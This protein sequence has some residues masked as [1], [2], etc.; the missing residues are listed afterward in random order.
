MVGDHTGSAGAVGSLFSR[1]GILIFLF[2][3]R[4]HH[5]RIASSLFASTNTTT[6]LPPYWV[7]EVFTPIHTCIH[8]Y[9]SSSLS[10]QISIN[11]A[12]ACESRVAI[13]E[14]HVT[15]KLTTTTCNQLIYTTTRGVVCDDRLD[16]W[17]VSMSGSTERKQ[18]RS[19]RESHV[20]LQPT[21]YLY[22]NAGVVCEDC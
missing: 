14:S 18:G 19:S 22:Y 5:H 2:H 20:T 7:C 15:N 10:S 11:S 3:H 12:G 4:H 21:I 17:P 13:A 1:I 9:H 8:G 16:R 6:T